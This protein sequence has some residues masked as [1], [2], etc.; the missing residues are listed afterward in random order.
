[1]KLWSDVIEEDLPRFSEH[2]LQKRLEHSRTHQ[3]Y[4]S[5]DGPSYLVFSSEHPKL[6]SLIQKELDRRL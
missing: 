3:T 6:Q 2:E 5:K 4:A 1:M